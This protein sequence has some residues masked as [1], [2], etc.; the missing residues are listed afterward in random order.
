[1]PHA[2]TSEPAASFYYYSNVGGGIRRLPPG[3]YG[4]SNHFLGTPWPKVVAAQARL[5]AAMER[6]E[7]DPAMLCDLLLDRSA[8]R[9][10][11]LPDTGVGLELERQLASSFIITPNYGT[12]STTAL[13]IE[14][15]G[16]VSMYEKSYGRGG[17][18]LGQVGHSFS[19]GP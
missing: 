3:T 2:S 7:R 15:T 19:R 5:A 1:M 4:L 8:P 6:R 18:L 12:R 16:A 11:E 14:A 9:D 10:A 13:V 17:L